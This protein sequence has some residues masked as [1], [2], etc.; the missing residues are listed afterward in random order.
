VWI[1]IL[2]AAVLLPVLAALG[3]EA[4][5]SRRDAALIPQVGRSVDIGGRSL[6]IS[7]AGQGT[8]AV[9]FDSGHRSPGYI[10]IAV[11]RQ[12]ASSTTACWHDRAGRGW[13]DPGPDPSWSDAAA[14]DL[15]MLLQAAGIPP[16]YVLVGHS[17]GG[18]TMRVYRSL[19]GA[20]V[21]GMVLVDA[22]HEDAATIPN[23]A[24]RHPPPV[25]R[26]LGVALASLAGRLGLMRLQG[27]GPPAPALSASERDTLRLLRRRRTMSLADFQESPARESGERARAAGPVGDL[28]L[29]VLT[30]GRLGVGDQVQR[31]WIALQRTLAEQSP[32]GRQVVV[33]E[34]GHGIPLTDPAAVASAVREVVTTVRAAN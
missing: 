28:P 22:A 20:E 13:S 15:H 1:R 21:A 18:Y 5:A 32:Q 17:S 10:W 9:V 6:N 23:L 30:A 25:P 19:Y 4:Y 31:D 29:I 34:S 16:P 26:W 12:V 2:A 27:D 24:G 11:Q 3:Y 7:C 8:P 33:A 14:R